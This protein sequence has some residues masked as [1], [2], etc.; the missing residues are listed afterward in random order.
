MWNHPE[1]RQP[2]QGDH[3]RQSAQHTYHSPRAACAK[4]RGTSVLA[5]S[6][7]C[8]FGAQFAVAFPHRCGVLLWYHSCSPVPDGTRCSQQKD[9]APDD[10]VRLAFFVTCRAATSSAICCL[11]QPRLPCA[12]GPHGRAPIR[13]ASLRHA[14]HAVFVFNGT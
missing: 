9:F 6:K 1:P 14:H 10:G 5:F 12:K 4:A 3:E 11:F 2:Q 7:A 13:N 8:R